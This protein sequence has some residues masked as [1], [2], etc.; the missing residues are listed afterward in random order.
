MFYKECGYELSLN[1]KNIFKFL[2]EDKFNN[3]LFIS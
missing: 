1:V 2:K 3:I